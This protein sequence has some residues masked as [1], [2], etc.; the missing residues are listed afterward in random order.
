MDW[1]KMSLIVPQLTWNSQSVHCFRK[2]KRNPAIPG[3]IFIMVSLTPPLTSLQAEWVE[4]QVS[5]LS[6]S[7]E[8][9]C[10]AVCDSLL[11]HSRIWV[12][13][14]SCP[15]FQASAA[16]LG[17]QEKPCLHPLMFSYGIWVQRNERLPA[18]HIA[19]GSDTYH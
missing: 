14:T 4:E 11:V 6:G 16:V 13:C 3:D 10:L 1:T 2:P 7:E 15:H 8:S 18:S 17:Q 9:D 19:L 5:T 12:P